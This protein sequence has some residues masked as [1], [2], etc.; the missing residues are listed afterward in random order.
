MNTE[1]SLKKILI[2]DDQPENIHILTE[3]LELKYDIFYAT[4]GEKALD[5]V[6]SNNRPD[7]ILLDIMM[8]GMNGYEV[9]TI[10]K[11]TSESHDIP[12]IFITSQGQETGET[13]GFRLGAVDYITKPFSIPVVEARIKAV[14]R[15][16]KEMNSRKIL[17]RKLEHL[18]MNLEE[19]IKEKT[20][21]L[22]QAHENLK[23]SEKKFRTI[24]ENALEGIFQ[25]TP[26]GHLLNVSPS[27]AKILGY[28]S[29]RNLISRT[30]DVTSLYAKS[31]D[32][33]E[34]RRILEQNGEIFD[35]ETQFIKQNGETIWVMLSAKVLS[36]EN[37]NLSLLQGFV[38]DITARRRASE[39]ELAN[40]QL[41]ELD[42]LKSALMSTASHDLRG[43]M[44]AILGFSSLI[45][46]DFSQHLYP[47][48]KG[49]SK[50][51]E[52]ARKIIDRLDIIESEGGRLI[53][54]VNDFLDISKLEAG[55][56]EWND[57][58]VRITEI[59]EQAVEIVRGQLLQSQ[60]VDIKV[61]A[62]PCI[63]I[64]LCD[65]DR[66]MQVMVNLLSNAIKFT[67]FGSIT[68]QV[69][70][71]PEDRIEIR[72]EDTGPGIPED[73]REKI[74]SKFYQLRSDETH[75][76]KGPEAKGTGLGLAICK[77]IIDHYRGK[78]WVESEPGN[79]STFIFQLPIEVSPEGGD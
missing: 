25:S 48:F 57:I 43:P 3:N 21:E 23:V 39:L 30:P 17:A 42:A 79:G 53:R 78:I 60:A 2:V 22:E 33:N 49:N 63:P 18:N 73:E 45:K 72:V 20:S 44:T 10:L 5:I 69:L 75:D 37:G 14:L 29:P 38:V 24:F 47:L 13:T 40:I 8:P 64:I 1:I 11:T 56:S 35:F 16:E 34:F 65:P 68:A 15:L 52:K 50:L 59:V 28:H 70:T 51:E 77:Q 54:I 67:E 61:D 71:V 31:E 6:F 32:R 27:L 66:L 9:C 58:P 26:D 19:K 41:R 7:L 36:D 4:T 76:K 12:V 46:L 74:F 55:C 62:K